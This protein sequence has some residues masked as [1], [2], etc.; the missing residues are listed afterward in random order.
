[1]PD[2]SPVVAARL[3]NGPRRAAFEAW[4]ARQFERR[5]RP[6]DSAACSPS[7]HGG[8]LSDS[9]RSLTVTDRDAFAYGAGP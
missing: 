7:R 3:L 9:T 1:M 6:S 8:Q 2:A 5:R 4:L